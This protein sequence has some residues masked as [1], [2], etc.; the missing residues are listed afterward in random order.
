MQFS[1][2][3]DDWLRNCFKLVGIG[4]AVLKVS[5]GIR[6]KSRLSSGNTALEHDWFVRSWRWLT[7]ARVHLKDAKMPIGR[8]IVL[9]APIEG[10]GAACSLRGA[11]GKLSL[12]NAQVNDRS[13]AKNT[14]ISS[15]SHSFFNSYYA[16]SM[17]AALDAE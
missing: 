9:I 11:S 16:R 14:A 7:K 2:M 12:I 3:I 10:G 1:S 15:R 13:S 5:S 8:I 17:R 6:G 4:P